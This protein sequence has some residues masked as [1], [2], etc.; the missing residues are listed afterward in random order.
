[1]LNEDAVVDYDPVNKAQDSKLL[2]DKQF[3]AVQ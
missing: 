3:R 2:E 1:V